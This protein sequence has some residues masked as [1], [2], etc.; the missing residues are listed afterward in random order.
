[1]P[2]GS[3]GPD[4]SKM[5]SSMKA[6]GDSPNPIF[7][8]RRRRSTPMLRQTRSEHTA[9]A[10]PD[11]GPNEKYLPRA[12]DQVGRVTYGQDWRAVALDD[13]EPTPIACWDDDID[14]GAAEEVA[15]VLRAS[16]PD[17]VPAT[18]SSKDGWSFDVDWA[19]EK[20]LWQMAADE[21]LA[22]RQTWIRRRG[23]VTRA[24]ELL[25]TDFRSGVI[26][27]FVRHVDGGPFEPIPPSDWNFEGHAARF[28]CGRMDPAAPF[29]LHADPDELSH[30]LFVDR[31][32]LERRFALEAD[33]DCE[34]PQLDDLWPR[35][36]PLM[37]I[38]LLAA[39][40]IRKSGVQPH[41]RG[42]TDRLM[43]MAERRGVELKP[44]LAG[45]MKTI[46]RSEEARLGLKQKK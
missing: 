34:R 46:I 31:L 19:C 23:H 2:L 39:N 13:P 28:E 5:G 36:S 43:A 18:D 22:A 6:E 20:A 21:R 14:I 37:Q 16:F 9:L 8:A 30:Y 12:V 27:T 7:A 44:T 38:A 40:E 33:E 4:P 3:M 15:E 17:Q 41:A 10:E 24:R 26:N 29:M 11:D 1:M 32:Q 45:S 35:L 25:L 42:L